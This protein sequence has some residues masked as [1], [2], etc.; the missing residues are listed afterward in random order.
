M[1]RRVMFLVLLLLLVSAC[2]N[3]EKQDG[4]SASPQT[5]NPLSTN[6]PA[7]LNFP[8][9]IIEGY[10]TQLD[11]SIIVFMPNESA[12]LVS[13]TVEH[14]NKMD[15]VSFPS[16]AALTRNVTPDGA[17][18]SGGLKIIIT[19]HAFEDPSNPSL[20][21]LLPANST[22]TSIRIGGLEAIRTE[23]SNPDL[24]QSE[25]FLVFARI[26]DTLYAYFEVMTAMG[27]KA[28]IEQEATEILNSFRV[29]DI[30]S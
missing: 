2:R 3:D 8:G 12:Q 17:L 16:H 27:E 1:I 4:K 24:T 5:V 9:P 10:S 30:Q 7:P 20:E 26:S 6:T 22:A 14:L 29:T 25:G 28:L 11:A 15:E 18:M 21:A 23:Y 19:I 13:F